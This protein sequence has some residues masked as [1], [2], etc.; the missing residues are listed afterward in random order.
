M[1][2]QSERDLS[3]PTMVVESHRE[4]FRLTQSRQ[5]PRILTERAEGRAQGK[6]QIDSLLTCGACLWQM[7]QGTECLLKIPT[8][9]AMRRTRHGLFPRLLTVGQSLIPHLT[10]ESVVREPFGLLY[11][12]V[13]GERL[14]GLHNTGMEHAPPLLQETAIGYFV[15]ERVLKCI[16]A[17]GEQAGLIDKLRRL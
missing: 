7:R 6:S 17:L 14:Q 5:A 16:F 2:H 1:D 13:P 4:G 12:L 11:H 10:P 3:Q 8:G 9:L 15:S